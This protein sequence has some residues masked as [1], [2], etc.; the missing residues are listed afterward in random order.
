MR[1]KIRNLIGKMRMKIDTRAGKL[2]VL[3]K[4]Q[5]TQIVVTNIDK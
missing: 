2:K 4:K 5:H 3:V 1:Y